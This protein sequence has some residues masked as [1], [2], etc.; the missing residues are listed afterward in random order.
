MPKK[1]QTKNA[2]A[3]LEVPAERISNSIKVARFRSIGPLVMMYRSRGLSIM[4]IVEVLAE[5]HGDWLE[6]HGLTRTPSQNTVSR[7][8]RKSL[9][10]TR[11]ELALTADQYREL[12]SGRLDRLLTCLDEGINDGDIKAIRTAASISEQRARLLGLNNRGA[13]GE[14]AE[15][16]LQVARARSESEAE[17]TINAVDAMNDDGPKRLAP[18]QTT[19]GMEKSLL[20]QPKPKPDIPLQQAIDMANNL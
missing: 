13:E 15:L 20:N 18:H 12:E 3:R 7:W 6:M 2:M 14:L 8:L 17:I 9:D 1:L 11:E 10:E 4:Q 5:S 16:L 19:L